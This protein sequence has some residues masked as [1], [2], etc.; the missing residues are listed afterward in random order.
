[1]FKGSGTET[2]AELVGI[3]TSVGMTICFGAKFPVEVVAEGFLDGTAGDF[4]RVVVVPTY[5][6]LEPTF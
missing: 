5:K 4:D 2:K 1:M 3:A 6:N